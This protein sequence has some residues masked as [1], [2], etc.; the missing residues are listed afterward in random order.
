[1]NSIDIDDLLDFCTCS[2]RLSFSKN[3][4]YNSVESVKSHLYSSL[5]DYCLYLILNEQP[6]TVFKLNEKLNYLWDAIKPNMSVHLSISE[7]IAIK[8]KLNKI[9]SIFTPATEVIYFNVPRVVDLDGI[10]FLY[11][12]SSYIKNDKLITVVKFTRSDFNVGASSSFLRILASIV[13]KD[14]AKLKDKID[15]TVYCF[16]TDTCDFYLPSLVDD[17]PRI[18]TSISAGIRNKVFVPKSNYFL[19]NSCS[20]K[21][22]CSFRYE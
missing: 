17:L 13:H 8:N 10:D 20:Y 4:V 7:K 12:F 2:Y 22:T 9:I 1:M 18:I 3:Q 19:C 6:I 14:L 5:F 15:H 16:K 11:T 21:Q